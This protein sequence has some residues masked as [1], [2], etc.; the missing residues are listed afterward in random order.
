MTSANKV[1]FD[2]TRD[3]KKQL[4]DISPSFCTAKWL[5]STILLYNG[6][7]HSCHHPSRH[8]IP[9]EGL[10][11]NPKLLHNTP[12]KIFARKEMLEGIQTKECEYCWRIEN[13]NPDNLSDRVYKSASPW[14]RP[15]FD[16]VVKSGLGEDV[17]PTYLEVAFESTCNFACM[18]CTPEVSTAWMAEAEKH[19][20]YVLHTTTMH[21]AQWLKQI[22][23]YPIHRDDYNPYIEAFW[24]WWPELYPKLDTFRI[25]GGEPLL[26]KHTWKVFEYIKENPNPK[27]EFAINTNMNVPRKLID[28][29]VDEI[30]E[31]QDKV[32]EVKLFTSFEATGSHAEYIRFG[33]V[34][35]EFIDNLDYIMTKL[36]DVRI[37]IMVTANALSMFTFA[38]F[39]K[40]IIS[41]RAKHFKTAAKSTLG[42]NVSYLRWPFFQDVRILPDEIKRRSTD[43]VLSV[44]N[45]HRDKQ[46]GFGEA[47]FYLEEID[48]VERFLKYMEQDLPNKADML[49][50]F[51]MFYNEY[52][53]RRNLNFSETFP[54]IAFMV[55]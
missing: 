21:S 20:H 45:S 50:D 17:A 4:D 46:P 12:V 19:G 34:Y 25:T 55:E 22:G 48:Q 41:L 40:Q 28:R 36:P 54:E 24:K 29:L 6:D 37:V 35:N 32:K 9:T 1:N 8:R 42:F 31:V 38:D 16:D 44:I 11:E 10:A 7:T 47:M 13:S 30:A 2:K 23:K 14:A 43:E 3:F 49:R 26:S 52:D 27:M 51:K 15:Y 18:Y 33:M 53:R 5:Q 39:L